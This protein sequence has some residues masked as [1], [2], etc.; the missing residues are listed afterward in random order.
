M[1]SG[2]LDSNQRS[3]APKA[4]A[5]P[6]FATPRDFD[7]T[8]A[9]DT[10]PSLSWDFETR[11]R[12]NPAKTTCFAA[13]GT[14]WHPQEKRRMPSRGETRSLLDDGAFLDE[15]EKLETPPSE[16]VSRPVSRAAA[17]STVAHAHLDGP[18]AHAE[19]ALRSRAT[20]HANT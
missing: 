15:L 1:K 8:S 10:D 5:I 6:G 18:P 7:H 16:S 14:A 2:R 3:S 17:A 20:I 19:P 12:H 11:H 9:P 4:D 13:P